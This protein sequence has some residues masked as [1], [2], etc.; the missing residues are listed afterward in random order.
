MGVL[1]W[2]CGSRR[3]RDEAKAEVLVVVVVVEEEKGSA[4]R[5]VRRSDVMVMG[6]AKRVGVEVKA[7]KASCRSAE[8]GGVESRYRLVM[9][10]F[11]EWAGV[12]M[13]G[14]VAG[15]GQVYPLCLTALWGGGFRWRSGGVDG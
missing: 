6:S 13:E 8:A 5:G 15:V 7:A 14:E 1:S 2:R 11:Y 10:S 4:G 12:G 9:G 3:G